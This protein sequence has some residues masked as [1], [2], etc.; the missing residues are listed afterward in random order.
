MHTTERI[1]IANFLIIVT[2][3][4]GLCLTSSVFD[5]IVSSRLYYTVPDHKVLLNPQLSYWLYGKLGGLPFSCHF[6]SSL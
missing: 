5:F 1:F 3:I 2:S 4:A 6:C